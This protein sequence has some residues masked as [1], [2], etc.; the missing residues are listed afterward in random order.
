MFQTPCVIFA[1]GKSSRMGED[2]SLLPFG[3]F[4]TLT[5]FQL[6][7]LKKIF[8]TVY[9][10][11]KDKNI[12]NFS[13]ENKDVYFIE[14]IK[15]DST[16]AP[17]LGFLSVFNQIKDDIFFALSVDSPLISQA[18]ISK[19]IEID[20]LE[21]D[22]TIAKT[23]FG[24]HPMCGV[25]HRS[26]HKEFEDMFKNDN[27]KLGVLLKNSNTNYVY[28]KDEKPFLNLNHP[29]EYQKALTLV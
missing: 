17:T 19:L 29:Y 7:R 9:I 12:Y 20:S 26:L 21:C 1:G 11:C 3:G 28:F 8:K 13:Q 4:N 10:S 18:E 25:Y 6:T 23:A 5:E 15:T 14:D 24:V 2:K 22:A 16:Y 27:H